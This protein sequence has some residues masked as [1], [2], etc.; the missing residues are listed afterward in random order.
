MLWGGLR[1]LTLLDEG[2]SL[3]NKVVENRGQDELSVLNLS[4]G[5]RSK[6]FPFFNCET[7]RINLPLGVQ[8]VLDG[9][10]EDTGKDCL[11][12]R[13]ELSFGHLYDVLRFSL[14]AY[15][16]RPNTEWP[17]IWVPSKFLDGVVSA[18]CGAK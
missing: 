8:I 5:D 9:A 6:A 12:V 10:V 15:P 1:A 18:L 14:I 3:V 7:K 17:R 11:I 13:I 4:V 2:V 16:F